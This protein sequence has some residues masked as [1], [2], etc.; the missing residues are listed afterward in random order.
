MGGVGGSKEWRR[1][2]KGGRGGGVSSGKGDGEEAVGQLGRHAVAVEGMSERKQARKSAVAAL[3]LVIALRAIRA[4]S[5][6]ADGE[7]VAAALDPDIRAGQARHFDRDEVGLR[8]F[9]QVRRRH[10]SRR[11]PAEQAVELLLHGQQVA[12]RIPW[13]DP[14]VA[15]RYN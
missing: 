1:V 15:N 14:I 6:A 4:G 12:R 5:F 11:R 2:V 13:H 10:P 7:I 3:E 8:A 9:M